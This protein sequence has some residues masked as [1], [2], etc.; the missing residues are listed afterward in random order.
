MPSTLQRKKHNRCMI[1]AWGWN[2]TH[3]KQKPNRF[4]FCRLSLDS[5]LI[6]QYLTCFI[7]FFFSF[8]LFIKS[9]VKAL[10]VLM[11]ELE[12]LQYCSAVSMAHFLSLSQRI[13]ADPVH[14]VS[15]GC[16][17]CHRYTSMWL[18]SRNKAGRETEELLAL[19]VHVDISIWFPLVGWQ[20]VQLT[21]LLQSVCDS[22]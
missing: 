18:S 8:S 19:V 2:V 6:I 5:P 3:R 13:F 17:P 11:C 21:L 1:T 16:Q 9:D 14:S 10:N 15:S 12:P 4:L 20:V 22:N 7:Y